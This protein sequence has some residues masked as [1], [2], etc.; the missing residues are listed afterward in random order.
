MKKYLLLLAFSLLHFYSFSQ[1]ISLKGQWRFAMDKDNIG[2]TEKW[3]AKKLSD[4]IQLPGSML[5]NKKG[6]KV[7]LA[8]K[9]TGSI[10]DSSWYFNPR[11][12]KYRKEDDLKFPFWLTPAKYYVGAA[13]YQ[14]EIIIPANFSQKHVELFLERCHT[15]T[16]LWIDGAYIGLQNSMVAPHVYDI[17]KHITTGKHTITL[18]IDNSIKVINVG[19]DSHS[20]TDHTQGNWNGVVGKME[21]QASST[22][23]ITNVQVYPN[24]ET[25][26]VQVKLAVAGSLK[27]IKSLQLSAQ[28]FNTKVQH[29]V[30]GITVSNFTVVTNDTIIV[31]YALGNNAQLWS[32]FNPALYQLNVAINNEKE[33]LNKA[34][35]SFG[36]R[37]FKVKGKQFSINNQTTF[38][39]GTVENCVFP[40]T[41][42]APM[43][44]ASWLRIF[45]I[46]KNYGLN[47]MRFHSYCP[48]EAAFAAADKLGFYLQPEGPSWANHGSSIGDKKPIDTFIYDETNRMQQYY[49]NHPSYCMLAYGNEPK[50]GHQV[51][52][53]TNFIHYW[54]NK[55]DRRVYTGA[56]VAMSWPLVPDNEFMIK[57]GA[58][59]LSWNKPPETQ[60]DY[61]AA[62]EK[63][64]MPYV[65]HEMGQWC[66]FP[67]FKEIT[68]YKGV[69]KA[70]N[71]E[72]FKEDI[73]DVGMADEAS[74]FLQA[75]GK[76]QLLCYKNE[77]EKSL[78]T[79]LN[80][81][82][83]LLSLN[84]YSGQGTALVGVLNAFWNEKGYCTAK[85]FSAFCNS[86]VPLIRTNK[87]EYTNNESLK[88]ILEIYHYG[89]KDFNNAM[90]QYQL[91][92]NTGKIIERGN[93][94]SINIPTGKNTI[95]GTLEISLNHI[96]TATQLN[97]E[98][99]IANTAYHNNWNFWVYPA[100]LNI[101]SNDVYYTT[102][103]DSTAQQ[104][105]QNGG[106]VFLNLAGKIVK[107]KEVVQ[108]FTPVFWNTSWFKM[109]PPHTTGIS[110]NAQHPAFKFFPTNNYSDIQWWSITN[111]QQ[112][113]HLEDFPK[114]FKPLVRPIDTWFMN[115]RL[116]LIFE[117]N[118]GKG[119]MIVSSTGINANSTQP[120]AKQLYYS[121]IQYMQSNNF[122]PQQTINIQL[123][124]DLL[125]QPSK[126]VFD[127]F[128]KDSPDELKPKTAITH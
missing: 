76:L 77:I 99:S 31:D 73:A 105:L 21:L 36:L 69:Y 24:I 68:Q 75:S 17:T 89:E 109:R 35:T 119:K 56:S 54:K 117:A 25:K 13:W 1:S 106:K 118:V 81:G 96:S 102:T 74:Q 32:E 127:A 115:R 49:G 58:R 78:R 97:L 107:G 39:R 9:W 104:I 114:D 51:E 57:S 100:Q 19:P 62:I 94:S 42:Y 93:F 60:S 82:F 52:Y 70:K 18:R 126:Y 72:L 98:V 71:F 103:L 66:A 26:S 48:P 27:Q 50:G 28:S 124:Q 41:G 91:K 112:V 113:M 47:H 29:V 3:F 63:F 34:T 43:D 11:F 128:T 23:H 37:S 61:T 16:M 85:D 80:G 123:I 92:D 40:L 87:F 15:E 7:T 33:T 83:Q 46:C 10:Y 12:A 90:V 22:T 86:T 88:A 95:I 65:A 122:K 125:T 30:K 108:T 121:L 79:P 14:K 20:L 120:A 59:N 4:S 6:D 44:E 2:I 101:N 53:L 116:A 38:L 67:D 110:L 111:K 84:D 5:Q 64:A 8:T 45:T 55:D